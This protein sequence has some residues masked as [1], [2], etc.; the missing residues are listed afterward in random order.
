MK[1]IINVS[2]LDDIESLF[3]R[4]DGGEEITID[5]IKLDLFID[6]LHALKDVD[7]C[8]VQAVA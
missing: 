3:A 8:Y 7:S 4:L 6:I 1:D 2:S 5:R